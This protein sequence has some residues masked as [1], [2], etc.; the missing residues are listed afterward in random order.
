MF[1]YLSSIAVPPVLVVG[2]RL[3][4]R[5]VAAVAAAAVV[6]AV[7]AAVGQVDVGAFLQIDR[8]GAAIKKT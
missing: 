7:A 3:L 4:G 2:Q 6:V 8:A 1:P 5:S